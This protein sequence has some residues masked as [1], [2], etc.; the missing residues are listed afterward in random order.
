MS[1]DHPLWRYF[2]ELNVGPFAN[3][4]ARFTAS[5]RYRSAF[6]GTATTQ[7][8]IQVALQRWD[9]LLSGRHFRVLGILE[10]PTRL[11]E[12]PDARQCYVAVMNVSGQYHKGAARIHGVPCTP[13]GHVAVAVRMTFW[14][15]RDSRILQVQ[16]D[17]VRE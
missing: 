11:G 5:A 8:T 2:N 16:E 1:E 7:D 15:D 4:L 17:I 9:W 12:T 14:L 3:A 6:G 13:D 10:E